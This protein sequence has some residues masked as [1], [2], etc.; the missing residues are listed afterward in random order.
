MTSTQSNDAPPQDIILSIARS[1]PERWVGIRS[2]RFTQTANLPLLFFGALLAVGFYGALELFEGRWI[3]DTLHRHAV[4]Y[5]IV[6]MTSWSLLTLLIKWRKIV[7]QRR[8]LSIKVVPSDPTFVLSVNTAQRML[9]GMYAIVDDPKEF[10]LLNRI[11]IALSNLRN[12]G[13]ISDVDD[14][15]QSQADLDE[16]VMES[17]YTVVRGLVW[18]IP[19]LGFIGT[20]IGLSEAIGS[21]G[22]VLENTSDVTALRDGLQDVTGGLGVAFETTLQAL[23]A[24]LGIHLLLTMI[25]RDEERFFNDC[26]EYC[27]KNIVGRLRIVQPQDA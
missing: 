22:G 23:V 18:G 2:G 7:V 13:R 21:F 14:I 24:A 4:T 12:I 25:R 17:S 27:Q 11:Q 3:H 8:A 6:L 20:V 16:L 19:V 5:I 26:R 10:V 9:N 15:L 1:D